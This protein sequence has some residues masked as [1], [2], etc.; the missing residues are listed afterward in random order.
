MVTELKPS[1]VSYF[2]MSLRVNLTAFPVNIAI[3]NVLSAV[4][5]SYKF[6][7]EDYFF[8][9]KVNV[10]FYPKITVYQLFILGHSNVLN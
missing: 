7:F 1:D 2:E 8:Q 9:V 3:D 4:L 5:F 10:P 6:I